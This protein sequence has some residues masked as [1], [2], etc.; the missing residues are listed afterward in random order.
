MKSL[1]QSFRRILKRCAV[2][3]LR[4]DKGFHI[5]G[6]QQVFGK[7]KSLKHCM[8]V[9]SV[10]PTCLSGDYNPLLH[11]CYQHGNFTACNT[12][13]V[14]PQFVHFSKVPCCEWRWFD[15][16][17]FVLCTANLYKPYWLKLTALHKFVF[18]SDLS[19]T[20]WYRLFHYLNGPTYPGGLISNYISFCEACEQ[21]SVV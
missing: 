16:M 7:F 19:L 15:F 3:I 11:K 5:L 6:G 2:K 17:C 21:S 12:L 9:C 10:T 18:N 13:R 1:I 14:H 8:K 20:E 4:V